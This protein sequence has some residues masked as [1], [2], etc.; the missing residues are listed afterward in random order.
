MTNGGANFGCEGR[1]D[2]SAI[3]ECCTVLEA[4]TF[5]FSLYPRPLVGPH[6]RFALTSLYHT[7]NQKV[8]RH[9]SLTEIDRLAQIA[10]H[11]IG[12]V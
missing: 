2:N 12:L 3:T 10:A 4:S 9:F 5:P 11:W 6:N 7:E 1:F 8:S